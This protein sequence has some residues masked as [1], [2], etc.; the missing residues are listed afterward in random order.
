VS[1]NLVIG[2]VAVLIGV[3]TLFV[4][5]VMPAPKG[6]MAD[7]YVRVMHGGWFAPLVF[8]LVPILAGVTFLGAWV[9]ARG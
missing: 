2:V 6:W 4:R 1:A 9:N 7:P 8:G 5:F 3:T